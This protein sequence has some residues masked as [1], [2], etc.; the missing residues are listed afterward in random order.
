MT[1]YAQSCVGRLMSG[2]NIDGYFGEPVSPR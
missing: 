1:P 2:V